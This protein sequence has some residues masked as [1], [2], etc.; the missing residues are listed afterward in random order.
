MIERSKYL[1]SNLISQFKQTN[2]NIDEPS[3]DIRQVPNCAA[4]FL[5]FLKG[6]FPL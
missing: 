3:H 4:D 6:T 5:T 2:G 1:G